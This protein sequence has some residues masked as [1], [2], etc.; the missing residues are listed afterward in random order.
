MQNVKMTDRQYHEASYL[1]RFR[2]YCRLFL[3]FWI[4]TRHFAFLAGPFG[5]TLWRLR[6]NVHCS[7]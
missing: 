3:K 7:P 5:I 1:V 2:G 6:G 4:K